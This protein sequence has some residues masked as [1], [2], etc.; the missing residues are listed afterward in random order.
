MSE[1]EGPLD[2]GPHRG[3]GPVGSPMAARGF[4]GGRWWTCCTT[5]GAHLGHSSLLAGPV[6]TLARGRDEGGCVCCALRPVLLRLFRV[7][8]ER[9][10][11]PVLFL[12]VGV[13][14]CNLP[15]SVSMGSPPLRE[16]VDSVPG[17]LPF[18]AL[19]GCGHPLLLLVRVR[20]LGWTMRPVCGMP[21]SR[22]VGVLGGVMPEGRKTLQA[23]LL[24]LRSEP[25]SS[26]LFLSAPYTA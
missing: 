23:V 12:C 19:W 3:C 11:R 8:L 18:W 4:A 13:P 9:V 20:L 1:E 10:P 14:E 26:E 6:G 25:G 5:A 7:V 24:F 16:T 22:R 2:P 17:G 21:E 15:T